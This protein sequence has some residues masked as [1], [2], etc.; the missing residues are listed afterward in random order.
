[1][2]FF[3]LRC[4]DVPTRSPP[5]M[6][7]ANDGTHDGGGDAPGLRASS[8]ED[9]LVHNVLV[10]VCINKNPFLGPF[11]CLFRAGGPIWVLYRAIGIARQKMRGEYPATKSQTNS[12]AQLGCQ[13]WQSRVADSFCYF[14]AVFSKRT[15]LTE[16][17]SRKVRSK[18]CPSHQQQL[19]DCKCIST[20]EPRPCPEGSQRV[21]QNPCSEDASKSNPSQSKKPGV[22]LE[23]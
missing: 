23:V 5:P 13:R 20:W 8:D 4:V 12:E 21:S 7:M 18:P 2:L 11:F 16:N 9:G 10:W 19:R 1:M 6:G 17:L 22:Y 14:W 15:F 3:A